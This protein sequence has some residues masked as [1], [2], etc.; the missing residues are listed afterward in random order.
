[1]KHDRTQMVSSIPLDLFFFFFFA[2][3]LILYKPLICFFIFFLVSTFHPFFQEKKKPE[4]KKKD[5]LHR[6]SFIVM[7]GCRLAF[8]VN[9]DNSY[10]LLLLLLLLLLTAVQVENEMKTCWLLLGGW[11]M[12]IVVP[13]LIFDFFFV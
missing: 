1:M 10:L 3:Y 2:W 9:F 6:H 5:I 11:K 7:V 13:F 12:N 4:K 8:D